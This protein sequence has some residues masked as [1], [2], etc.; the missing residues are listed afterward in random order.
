MK[1]KLLGIAFLLCLIL[2]SVGVLSGCSAENITIPTDYYVTT[3]PVLPE[4]EKQYRI[5]IINDSENGTIFPKLDNET[6]SVLVGEG[7]SYTVTVK[8][9]DGYKLDNL[10]LDGEIV[11]AKE[12]YTFTNI[13]SNHSISAVFSKILEEKEIKSMSLIGLEFKKPGGFS[14]EDEFNFGIW[15][16]KSPEGFDNSV[17][18]IK[19]CKT[20]LYHNSSVGFSGGTNIVHSIESEELVYFDGDSVELYLGDGLYFSEIKFT[21]QDMKFIG[22]TFYN[23]YEVELN[24][25]WSLIPVDAESYSTREHITVENIKLYFIVNY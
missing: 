23:V 6:S 10:L 19:D 22:N 15:Q 9:K 25:N 20:E 2:G 14:F 16:N 12:I 24:Q 1:K 13:V 18:Y 5:T 21:K 3:T 17:V 4:N 8:P 7:D 11:E